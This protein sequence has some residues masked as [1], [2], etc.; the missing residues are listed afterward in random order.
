MDGEAFRSER[1]SAAD[2]KVTVYRPR[3]R[4][5][6]HKECYAWLD[7]VRRDIRE[8]HAH[9]VLSC[10]DLERIDSTGLGLVASIHVSATKAGGALY[11]TGLP[12]SLRTLF[13]TAWL[14]KVMKNVDGEEDAIRAC[15]AEA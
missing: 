8:G 11:L 1:T 2:G 10:R 5:N 15:A 13:E 6:G 14:L 3:G 4:L 12:A 7:E 9:L